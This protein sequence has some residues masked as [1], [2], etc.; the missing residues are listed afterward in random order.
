MKASGSLI[1]FSSYS[2]LFNWLILHSAKRLKLN[3]KMEKILP[4]V[5]GDFGVLEVDC[6][7]KVFS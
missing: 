1:I 5:S 3:L 6:V 2:K 7:V 4:S